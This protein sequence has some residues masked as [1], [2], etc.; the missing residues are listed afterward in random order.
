MLTG[1]TLKEK[2]E[3]MEKVTKGGLRETEGERVEFPEGCWVEPLRSERMI[4]VM[5][6]YRWLKEQIKSGADEEDLEE[7][8]E[9]LLKM[10]ESMKKLP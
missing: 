10:G 2:G 9:R 6:M 7:V 1:E 5:E 3:D 4:S 8:W